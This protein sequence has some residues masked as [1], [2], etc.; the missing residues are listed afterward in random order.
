[1]VGVVCCAVLAAVVEENA[2]ATAPPKRAG[3]SVVIVGGNLAQ[4]RLARLT[5]LRVGG[6]TIRRVVFRMP[7]VA[8]RHE[9]VH[10]VELDVGSVQP[11]SRP[12]TLRSE[13]EQRLYIGTYFALMARYPHAAVAAAAAADSEMPAGRAPAYDLWSSLPRGIAVAEETRR[14]VEAA[15]TRR[16]RVLELRTASTPAR[17][18][19]ITLS[20]DDPAAFLKRRAASFLQLLYRPRIRLLG[21]YVGVQDA[22]GRLV[23]ATSRLPNEGAVYAIPSLDAC[24]PVSHGEPAGAKQ[25]PCPA[26]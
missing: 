23:W 26:H 19:A 13:W 2:Y 15:E 9:H 22:S 10:G 21:F 11:S 8:L 16:A 3:A 17:A 5:A 12:L 24:S 14:L 18:I 7:S 4:R 1:V 6:V 20:V 25:L